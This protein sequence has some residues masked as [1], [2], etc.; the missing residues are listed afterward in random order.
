MN[1]LKLCDEVDDLKSPPGISALTYCGIVLF[2][3]VLWLLKMDEVCFYQW[4]HNVFSVLLARAANFISQPTICEISPMF[5]DAS[6]DFDAM[7][8]LLN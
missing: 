1:N 5:W 3:L 8:I 2:F 4:L 6:W 7:F